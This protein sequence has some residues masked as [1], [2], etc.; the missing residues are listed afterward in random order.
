[1]GP[2]RY[3]HVLW[4]A[5]ALAVV[6]FCTIGYG[7]LRSRTKPIRRE[8][9]Q[10]V[11]FGRQETAALMRATLADDADHYWT[12]TRR[13]ILTLE[14]RLRMYAWLRHPTLGR[15]LS[16]Y[17]R[18]YYGFIRDGRRRVLIVG[19]CQLEG[20]DWMHEFVSAG[21]SRD[22]RFEAEYDVASGE[23]QHLWTLDSE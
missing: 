1:M 9:L 3:R 7:A 11:I 19:F 17:T 21:E 6:L 23:I 5:C 20:L 18:Q 4:I 2:G 14:E 8:G 22:C 12:P 10:G 15:E 13:Q 16:T